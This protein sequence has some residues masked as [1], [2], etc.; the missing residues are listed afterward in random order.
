MS[1]PRIQVYNTL[2]RRLEAFEPAKAGQVRMYVCGMTVYDY[3]HIGHARAMMAFDLVYRHL[4][5]RG[6]EVTYVRNHTDVDD[7]IIARAQELGQDPLDLSAEFIVALDEDL[8]AIGIARPTFEPKVSENIDGIVSLVAVLIERGHAYAAGGDV[9]FAVDSFRGYG[10]LSGKKLEDLVSGGRVEVNPHKRNPADFALWKGAKEGEICWPS[11]WGPGRPGWHIECS[12]MAMKHLGPTID[13]HGGGIDLVFP[14][15]ENEIAQSEGATGEAPFSKVWMHN[16]H[17]TLVDDETG[18]PVKMSKSLGNIVRI[19]DLVT[20]APAEALRLIYSECHYRSP[21]PYSNTRLMEAVGSL[22][23]LYEAKELVED[24]V[25]RGSET[26]AAQL[27]EEVGRDAIQLWELA[28]TFEARFDAAM[29]QDFNSGKAIGLLF[30]L[31]RAINRAGN[32]KRVRKVGTQLFLPCQR[33]FAL[34]AEVLGIGGMAPGAF[35]DELKVKRL[36]VE[37]LS[38]G[39][40]DER[41]AARLAAR[42]AKDW[43][44]ADAIRDELDGAGIV[45]MDRPS[46]VEWRVRV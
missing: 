9:F 26:P 1:E 3:C 24:Q 46:G 40:V 45:V 8:D 7:K 4:V 39:W 33:A 22:N 14:H 36:A 37:G 16:G 44:A 19:R 42:Q 32:H 30:E 11:P 6:Y 15:H 20:V 27:R 41:I 10:K 21:L 29:D 38:V 18:E 25:A 28:T 34:T 31:V 43:A 2:S 13:L 23:R 12:V 35:F 17:L 5:H